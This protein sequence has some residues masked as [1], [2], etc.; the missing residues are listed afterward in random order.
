M[1]VFG[2]LDQA[3]NAP[4]YKVLAVNNPTGI[5][6]YGN[7]TPNAFLN[8]QTIGVFG[9]DRTEANVGHNTGKGTLAPGWVVARF[10]Q[11]PVKSV[12]LVSG[13][14]GYSNTDTVKISGGVT[15]AVAT[16]VTNATGGITT[17]ALTTP[18]LFVN[19][20][21]VSFANSTAGV[22]SGTGANVAYTL[23]GK[24]GRATFE[25]LAFVRISSENAADNATFPNT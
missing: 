3:N 2:G 14:T 19:T 5:T 13:G 10:G 15:N 21:T 23:G 18:G 7:T 25:T 1:P 11:G 20:A 17:I 6:M 22:S 9:V 4:R 24:A 12:A 8:G 16:M